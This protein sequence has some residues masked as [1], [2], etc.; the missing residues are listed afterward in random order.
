LTPDLSEGGPLSSAYTATFWLAGAMVLV[1]LMIQ[2]GIAALRR[3]GKS[4][5][6]ALLGAAQFGLVWV[7]WIGYAAGILA[8]AGG[9]THALM[10]SLLHVDAFSAWHPWEGFSTSDITDGTVATVLGVLGIFVIFAAFGHLLVILARAAALMVLAATNPI[11]ASGLVWEGGR[12]WFWKAFRWF[13][14]AAFTPTVMV[15]LLGLGA[16]LTTGVALGQADALQTAIGTAVPGVMLILISCFAPLAL[17][18]LLA[19]VDPGTSSGAAMRAGLDA[20]GGFSGLLS[21]QP[22]AGT[23]DAASSSDSGGRSQG[24]A[25]TEAAT[26]DRFSKSAQG[27]LGQSGVG[28]GIA[29]AWSTASGIGTRAA[30]VGADLTNQMGIGHNTYVPDTGGGGGGGGG[31]SGGKGGGGQK[32]KESDVPDINGAGGPA[33]PPTAAP[34]GGLPGSG[35][36]SP[37]PSA[38]GAPGGGGGASGGGAA[39][40]GEAAAAVPIIPV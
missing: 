38:G 39:A 22:N 35:G 30:S 9:L 24:E 5:G 18:K 28:A 20:Q 36:G 29:A 21:G 33:G 8:A 23:S 26:D 13:H 25:S 15:L 16:Q 32:S 14:A 10:Q 1:F 19:F 6:T 3:D 17:F 12:P 34:T 7:A 40:G 27:M 2:L 11:S 31:K 37:M 4:L